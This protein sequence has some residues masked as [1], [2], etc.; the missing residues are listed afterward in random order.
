MNNYTE[1][2]KPLIVKALEE[3]Y[4]LSHIASAYNLSLS[5]VRKVAESYD[6]FYVGKA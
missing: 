4:K 1:K 3:G 6:L 2:L 5:F